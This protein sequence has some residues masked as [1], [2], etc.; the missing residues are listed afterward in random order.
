MGGTGS[1]GEGQV[2]ARL[3]PDGLRVLVL[4]VTNRIAEYNATTRKMLKLRGKFGDNEAEA[5]LK[6]FAETGK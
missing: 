1:D 4:S 6:R 5:Q 2:D 3:S